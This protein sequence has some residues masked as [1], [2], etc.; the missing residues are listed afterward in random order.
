MHPD[1][2]R[3]D[4]ILFPVFRFVF[5]PKNIGA[6]SLRVVGVDVA[7]FHAEM[8]CSLYIVNNTKVSVNVKLVFAEGSQL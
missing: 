3:P 5:V 8:R 7:K 1:R 4:L 6:V 2:R